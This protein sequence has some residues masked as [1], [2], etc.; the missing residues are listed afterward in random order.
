MWSNRTP[1]GGSA[2]LHSPPIHAQGQPLRRCLSGVGPGSCAASLSSWCRVQGGAVLQPNTH[3][4]VGCCCCC[5]GMVTKGRDGSTAPR[6]G[7]HTS[8]HSPTCCTL[9]LR[10]GSFCLDLPASRSPRHGCYRRQGWCRSRLTPTSRA[11]WV[12][13]CFR[14]GYA[15]VA[16]EL[17]LSTGR[18]VLSLPNPIPHPQCNAGHCTGGGGWG[19]G[20]GECIA[21]MT[22]TRWLA[23]RGCC[24]SAPTHGWGPGSRVCAGYGGRSMESTPTP[25]SSHGARGAQSFAPWSGCRLGPGLLGAAARGLQHV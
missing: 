20:E 11:R 22:G 1:H 17:E 24:C 9:L 6:S 8:T 25:T 5:C 4:G 18:R 14:G 15:A 19:G 13:S 2:R 7:L 3:Y 23:F 12:P 21:R 10:G 16:F